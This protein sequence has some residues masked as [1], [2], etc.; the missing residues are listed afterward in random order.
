MRVIGATVAWRLAIVGLLVVAAGSAAVLVASIQGMHLQDGMSLVDGYWI[1]LLP[2][3][4]VGTWLIPIGG[5][6]AFVGAVTV[7]WL[8][9]SGWLPR[10]STV[11]A[12]AIVGFWV[13]LMGIET[14]PRNAVDGSVS[15]SSVA[16]AV[17]SSPQNTIVLL[18]LPMTF[19]LTVALL[20]G[21]RLAE[22]RSVRAGTT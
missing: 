7:V 8:R 13:L 3:I 17:Y 10:L 11:P 4:A 22:G 18:L 16:D 20:S 9:P 19:V 1:G 12:V 14:T 21:R 6:V 15:A 5:I 2:W